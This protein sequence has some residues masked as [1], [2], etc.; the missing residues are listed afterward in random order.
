MWVLFRVKFD[1]CGNE[2]INIFFVFFV[3]VLHQLDHNNK[4]KLNVTKPR[5]DSIPYPD[6]QAPFHVPD[7]SPALRRIDPGSASTVHSHCVYSL[8][9]LLWLLVEQNYCRP[10]Y[11]V[12][13]DVNKVYDAVAQK[14]DSHFISK[15]IKDEQSS[16]KRQALK[17]V[18]STV[19][20]QKQEGLLLGW[21]EEF[22]I[23][24]TSLLSSS[25]T[26]ETV[27]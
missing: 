13:S 8:A 20:A 16:E 22:K 10:E 25:E 19:K 15:R 27:I 17:I 1:T 14:K 7:R 3:S 9:V 12:T 11:A 24:V 2:S 5:D 18:L 4:A 21:L 6:G 23:T 26:K